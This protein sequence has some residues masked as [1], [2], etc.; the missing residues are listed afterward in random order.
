MSDI[1][2][3]AAYDRIDPKKHFIPL[4]PLHIA[5]SLV[6]SGY[7]VDFKDYQT[8]PYENPFDVDTFVSFLSGCA[9]VVGIGCMYDM[10]PVV[11][12]ATKKVK[13]LDPHKV[14]VLGGA[15][16]SGVAEAIIES[17]PWIDVVVRG[18]A[19]DTIVELMHY[20]ESAPGECGRVKGVIV[21]KEDGSA[22]TAPARELISDLDHRPFPAY[23][24]LDLEK[25]ERASILTTRGCPHNCTFCD[26]STYW[27]AGLV[28]E[29]WITS[30][31]KFICCTTSL[32]RKSSVSMTIHSCYQNSE[33]NNSAKDCNGRPP[34]ASGAAW[35]AWI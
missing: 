23:Q 32:G 11:I 19:D 7:K 16:P 28:I 2:I 27:G 5:T 6:Q 17:F 12:L 9:D 18:E 31:G 24:L 35:D 34:A 15:G 10:L 26:I 25:Y 21:R 8:Y 3:V 20:L 14:F 1:S 33:C 30:S 29:T 22:W 13:Q 4:G